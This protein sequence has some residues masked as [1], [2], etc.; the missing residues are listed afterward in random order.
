[1]LK[2]DREYERVE[3][4]VATPNDLVDV[5]NGRFSAGNTDLVAEALTMP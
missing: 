2:T 5:S 3:I 1:M 4:S